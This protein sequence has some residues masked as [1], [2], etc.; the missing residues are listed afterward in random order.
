MASG[1]WQQSQAWPRWVV[2][3]V[4]RG[5]KPGMDAEALLDHTGERRADS[6]PEP[7]WHL[8]LRAAAPDTWDRASG[9]QVSPRPLCSR[10]RSQREGLRGS[11]QHGQSHPALP[12]P[13]AQ[14]DYKSVTPPPH[15]ARPEQGG[16]GGLG[17]RPL[18]G[19]P[20]PAFPS[21][22]AL[23]PRRFP[24]HLPGPGGGPLLRQLGLYCPVLL[25][26]FS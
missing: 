2:V 10:H 1:T 23:P 14:G 21:A 19:R 9:T 13:Q 24:W 16:A 4:A 3:A 5:T 7:R 18:L 8:G 6:G 22:R 26:V 15:P 20:S 12:D 11:A 25:T 17:L